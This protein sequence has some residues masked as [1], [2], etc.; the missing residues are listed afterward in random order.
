MVI[1]KFLSAYNKHSLCLMCL[2]STCASYPRI[3]HFQCH[4]ENLTHGLCILGLGILLVDM[5]NQ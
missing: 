1:Q 4:K 5:D 2:Q 3:A